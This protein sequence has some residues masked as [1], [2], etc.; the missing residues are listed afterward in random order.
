MYSTDP[1]LENA[2]DDVQ[3]AAKRTKPDAEAPRQVMIQSPPAQAVALRM[4]YEVG[5]SVFSLLA[6]VSQLLEIH[7]QSPNKASRIKILDDLMEQ[8]QQSSSTAKNA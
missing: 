4:Q 7:D 8:V 5:V 3:R 1:K 6:T 2:P